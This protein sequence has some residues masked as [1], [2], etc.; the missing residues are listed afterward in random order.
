[1]FGVGVLGFYRP[2]IGEAHDLD[3]L[4][5]LH[6]R[7]ALADMAAHCHLAPE[8]LRILVMRQNPVRPD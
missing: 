6:C 7:N 5:I 3:G 1:M 8:A 2:H 4:A